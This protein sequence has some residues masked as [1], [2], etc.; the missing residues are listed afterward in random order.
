MKRFAF[1]LDAV[2]G[3][4][5]QL[6]RE[7]QTGLADAQRKVVEREDAVAALAE[8]I[9]TTFAEIRRVEQG[10]L[11]VVRS[12][13]G[14]EHLAFLR[15]DLTEARLELRRSE[16]EFAARREDYLRARMDRQVLSALKARR[17][18]RHERRAGRVEQAELDEVARLGDV[19]RR[20]G[21]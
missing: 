15:R 12:C 17:L 7:K 21:S 20:T 3:Y 6:E 10:S 9:Q 18:D 1:G 4:R 13:E 19:L 8:A 14:R 11:D 5:E 2:L 16:A